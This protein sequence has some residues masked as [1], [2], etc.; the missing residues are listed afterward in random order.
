MSFAKH[1]LGERAWLKWRREDEAADAPAADRGDR[2]AELG[3]VDRF[4]LVSRYLWCP[5]KDLQ[6]KLLMSLGR[7][8]HEMHLDESVLLPSGASEAEAPGAAGGSEAEDEGGPACVG[9]G[10]GDG[11]GDDGGDDGGGGGAPDPDS[12]PIC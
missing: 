8:L 5:T 12:L 6:R 10:V 3:T 7:I 4:L 9:D 2:L 11:G 1:A